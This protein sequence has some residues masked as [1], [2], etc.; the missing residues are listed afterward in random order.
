[1]KIRNDFVSNSSSS[2][3]IVI[4]KNGHYEHIDSFDTIVLPQYEHGCYY[5]GW[6]TEKYF[7]IWSKLN[8][9]SLLCI[10]QLKLERQYPSGIASSGESIYYHDLTFEKMQAALIRVCKKHLNIDIKLNISEKNY[11]DD[12]EYDD[13]DLAYIDHQS[14]IWESPENARMFESDQMLYDF[15]ANSNSYIDN[16]NDNEGRIYD[17][18]EYGVGY[19]AR[20][21]DYSGKTENDK[22]V[23]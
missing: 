7:D 18:Y 14:G 15:L 4:N 6:Q 20:P 10:E 21:K 5:F 9:C 19:Y 3:F 11:A 16:S 22:I 1:M 17:P 8:W 13:M 2:S 12:T 23:E